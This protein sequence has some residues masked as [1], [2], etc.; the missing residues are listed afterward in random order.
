MYD[1]FCLKE[2]MLYLV[3][4]ALKICYQWK[5]SSFFVIVLKTPASVMIVF[6]RSGSGNFERNL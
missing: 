1:Y 3:K 4:V 6:K 5:G 2:E